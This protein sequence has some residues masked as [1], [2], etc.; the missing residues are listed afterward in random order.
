MFRLLVL[1]LHTFMM[2]STILYITVRMI[3]VTVLHTLYA[4]ANPMHCT[5]ATAKLHVSARNLVYKK[6]HACEYEMLTLRNL[7]KVSH[8]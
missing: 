6:M 7:P 1:T 5:C 2:L 4:P 8:L 3:I